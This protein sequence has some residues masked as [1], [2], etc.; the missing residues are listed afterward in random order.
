M[1][2]SIYKNIYHPEHKCENKEN[3]YLGDK[4]HS[5]SKSNK[6]KTIRFTK[7]VKSTSRK[8]FNIKKEQKRKRKQIKIPRNKIHRIEVE[9]KDFITCKNSLDE[10]KHSIQER[11]LSQL[12]KKITRIENKE[13]FLSLYR[14]QISLFSLQE[15][16]N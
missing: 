1:M 14:L 5:Y 3:L 15:Q 4:K 9:G 16:T 7:L 8:C 11:F 10:H 2:Y 12:Q 6:Y 13:I